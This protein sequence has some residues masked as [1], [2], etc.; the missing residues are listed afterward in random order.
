MTD[1]H[2]YDRDRSRLKATHALELGRDRAGGCGIDHDVGAVA[3]VI[4]RERRRHYVPYPYV[5]VETLGPDR[6]Q[7]LV[8][9]LRLRITEVCVAVGLA[10]EDAGR[11]DRVVVQDQARDVG[12]SEHVRDPAAERAAAPDRDGL[13]AETSSQDPA[14]RR[15]VTSARSSRTEQKSIGVTSASA[16][17]AAS[18]SARNSRISSLSS[19]LAIVARTPLAKSGPQMPDLK[20]LAAAHRPLSAHGAADDDVERPALLGRERPQPQQGEEQLAVDA[21]T[22]ELVEQALVPFGYSQVNACG[23][24]TAIAAR[25]GHA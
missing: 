8:Q 5:D 25:G 9:P 10:Y 19:G 11:D 7:A 3:P 4:A 1:E 6:D 20:V 17:S 15:S 18:R 22:G 2:R 23:S 12:T 16:S 21:L 14:S 13:A 24:R